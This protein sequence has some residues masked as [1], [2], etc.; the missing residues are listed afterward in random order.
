MGYLL[1][2]YSYHTMQIRRNGFQ[3]ISLIHLKSKSVKYFSG[4]KALA[5]P[6]G[7]FLSGCI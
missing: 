2:M 1:N 5:N 6:F 4:F 7:K 3:Q